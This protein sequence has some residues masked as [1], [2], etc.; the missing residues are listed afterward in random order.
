MT[1]TTATSTRMGD[2]RLL[3]RHVSYQVRLLTRTPRAVFAGA[4]FPIVL[5]LLRGSGS[6]GSGSGSGTAAVATLT[7]GLT[8]LG[9]A[10]TAYLTHAAG[11][12]AARESGVLRRWRATPLP[13]AFFFAGRI[14]ATVVL[15]VAGGALT[16]AA[17]ATFYDLP[18]TVESSA[19]LLATSALGALAWA[20]L[21][22]AA[23]ALVPTPEG[24]QPILALTFYPVLL[25]SG[26]LGPMGG[27]PSW[28]NDALAWLPAQP[29]IDAA[30]HAIGHSGLPMVDVLALLGWT[31]VGVAM[32]LLCFRWAPRRSAG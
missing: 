29:M 26:A 27:L 4:V 3:A 9:V 31:V 22:T 6:G 21:G 7:A 11:L 18:L 24:A 16:V 1:A 32:S 25:L 10:S 17:A 12:V 23:T 2:L 8:I 20:A 14:L 28:L 30:Q 13:R 5:L 19:E 15:A